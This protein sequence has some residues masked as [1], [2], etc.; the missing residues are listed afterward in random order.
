MVNGR[1]TLIYPSYVLRHD[2]ILN[3][4][5]TAIKKFSMR[6]ISILLGHQSYRRSFD[7]PYTVVIIFEIV[8]MGMDM[9]Y[10]CGSQVLLTDQLLQSVWKTE[11]R[12]YILR[13]IA[14]DRGDN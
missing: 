12:C 6:S 7:H 13:P 1:G 14:M 9:R 4:L 10:G 11:F 2:G 3:N 8:S 5:E